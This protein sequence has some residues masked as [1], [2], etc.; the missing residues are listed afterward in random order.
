PSP[1]YYFTGPAFSQTGG[2]GD[3]REAHLD[4]CFS[5]GTCA[6]SWTD[7]MTCAWRCAMRSA[8]GRTPSRS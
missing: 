5:H 6:G 2:H 7:R 4:S 1:R 3:P 8:P